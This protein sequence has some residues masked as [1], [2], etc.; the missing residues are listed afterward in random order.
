VLPAVPEWIP[1]RLASR[2]PFEV[3]QCA[4]ALQDEPPRAWIVA[5]DANQLYCLRGRQHGS[6]PENRPNAEHESPSGSHDVVIEKSD[7]GLDLSITGERVQQGDLFVSIAPS[8]LLILWAGAGANARDEDAGTHRPAFGLVPLP[9]VVDPSRAEVRDHGDR[10]HLHL[11]YIG[12]TH[13]RA[14]DGRGTNAA[15]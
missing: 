13:S 15:K 11:P 14:T 6:D 5:M 7:A 12:G 2:V 8:S 1:F 9:A 4:P 3:C 10:V